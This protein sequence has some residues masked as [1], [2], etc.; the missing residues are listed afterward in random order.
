M[1]AFDNKY[2]GDITHFSY[3]PYF[4]GHYDHKSLGQAL[5][6][7][8]FDST[9][10]DDSFSSVYFI[11]RSDILQDK[12]DIDH[13][14]NYQN[15]L[16]KLTYNSSVEN[17]KI[18]DA[19]DVFKDNKEIGKIGIGYRSAKDVQDYVYE[20]A[21]NNMLETPIHIPFIR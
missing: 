13:Y 11:I 12:P 16:L 9:V 19:L 20:K 3:T 14:T 2:G 4:D 8:Y 18:L 6:E 7:L 5:T 21:K 17:K 1:M 10:D 15:K